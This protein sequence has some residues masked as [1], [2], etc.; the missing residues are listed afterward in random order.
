MES[1]VL[2]AWSVDLPRI[3]FV[4]LLLCSFLVPFKGIS[5]MTGE[6]KFD[7]AFTLPDLFASASL[8]GHLA[9]IFESAVAAQPLREFGLVRTKVTAGQVN[10]RGEA[11]PHTSSELVT[12][13]RRGIAS[14]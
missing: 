5:L 7:E 14:P 4:S 13:T 11:V 6:T 3:K 2:L 9:L 8:I 12:Q 1:L 10:R